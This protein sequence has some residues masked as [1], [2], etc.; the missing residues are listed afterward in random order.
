MGVACD[1]TETL[2]GHCFCHHCI[3][4][5]LRS[6]RSGA[7]CP[8]CRASLTKDA[9]RVSALLRR[10]IDDQQV[11][12]YHHPACEWQGRR[13]DLDTHIRTTCGAVRVPCND[14]GVEWRRD[15]LIS[16]Q[17]N[18]CPRRLVACAKCQMQMR[19]EHMVSHGSECLRELVDCPN[20]CGRQT[21]RCV[22][23]RHLQIECPREE[24]M[25]RYARFGCAFRCARDSMVAH[26]DDREA[27]SQHARQLENKVLVLEE[28]VLEL[29]Y[30]CCGLSERL[31]RLE[32]TGLS[33]R[34]TVPPGVYRPSREF[35][36]FSSSPS[37]P[38]SSLRRLPSSPYAPVSTTVSRDRLRVRPARADSSERKELED[39]SARLLSHTRNR[40]WH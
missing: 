25:C 5:H 7:A 31:S 35:K 18:A 26:L 1:I 8:V 4:E 16:H 29:R 36:H 39:S 33:R 17:T 15:A 40:T 10:L 23:E 24:M 28:E 22:M 30:D 11:R 37:V 6:S 27:M 2:C 3:G 19:A 32:M 12:C 13:D 38:D 34:T 14:C 9:L 20:A 21:E